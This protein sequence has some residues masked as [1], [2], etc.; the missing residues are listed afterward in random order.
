M[1]TK[2]QRIGIAGLLFAGVTLF[3]GGCGHEQSH[4]TAIKNTNEPVILGEDQTRYGTNCIMIGL[5]AGWGCTNSNVVLLGRGA[6]TTNDFELVIRFRD[7][8]EFRKMLPT[9]TTVDM[10]GMWRK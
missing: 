5:K 9:N 8:S 10:E 4:S 2:M 3:G 6:T 7:G 1:N